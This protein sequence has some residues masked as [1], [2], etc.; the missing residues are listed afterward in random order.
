MRWSPAP[1]SLSIIPHLL[2]LE[3]V[4]GEHFV[5][6][7]MLSLLAGCA[8]STRDIEEEASH[9]E[10]ASRAF[11]VPSTSTNGDSS[12]ASPGPGR[13]ERG[14]RPARL[15]LLRKG[16]GSAPRVPQIRKK[17]TCQVKSTPG[18]QVEDFIPWVRP[19]PSQPS[20]SEEDEEEKEMTGLL[21][22][23]VARKRKRQEDIEREAD[24][25]EGSNRLPT[26]GG[27]E[28]QEI[29]IP[30][31]PKTG[32]NDQSGPEDIAHG[33]PRK[34]TLIPP[35]LQVIHPPN[36]L[37]SRPSNAKL[38]LPG[39]KRPLL[40]DRILLNSYLPPC[41]PALAMEK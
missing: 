37:E 41:G 10:Q 40:P 27:S 21:D 3:I 33:G 36:R 38:A 31:S 17:G 4:D 2:H 34:S 7:D 16:T 32:S 14:I 9:R 5:T 8:P 11:S 22:R 23:Y 19:E 6:S 24:R 39:R 13:D 28:M 12:S 30:G 15:P 20:A 26:D 35:A 25:V 29:V 1:Y 18:A